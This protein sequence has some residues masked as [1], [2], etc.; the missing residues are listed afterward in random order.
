MAKGKRIAFICHP[1]H[2]GGVTR[3][4]ADAANEWSGQGNEVY[5]VT[6]DPVKEF[7]SAHG[8]ET[9]IQLIRKNDQGVK[10]LT[11]PAGYEFEFGT[12][13]YR[14]WIYK[15]LIAQIPA[16]TPIILSDDHSVWAAAT[17]LNTYYPVIGVMHADENHY[18]D[19]A[20][21]YFRQVDVFTCVSTRVNMITTSRVPGFDPAHIYTIPC[22]INL[23][24][25]TL[26]SRK[27]K[28]LQLVFV[29]RIS[30][31]QKRAG[32][33]VKIADLLAK[34]GV[35]FRMKIIGE[36]PLKSVLESEVE[37]HGLKEYVS[38][39]GWLSQQEVARNLSESDI[40]V[41]T[42]DFEG[43]PIAMMEAFAA[44]CGMVGTRVS[45]IEDYERHPLAG[46]CLGVYQVGAIEEAVE[47][48]I[49]ISKI[50]IDKRKK[51]ARR[52]A[53]SEFSMQVCLDRY[54]IAMGAI[55]SRKDATP[56]IKFPVGGLIYSRLIALSRAI[57]V[58]LMK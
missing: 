18:Y 32:D 17:A 9:L 41:L 55:K 58:R 19:L 26:S 51:A 33:L 37:T 21:K 15:K 49:R 29:G 25:F 40:L 45:G 22:G 30:E 27:D 56:E 1:Y 12:P 5:F 3:W 31:Y 13:E 34:K 54:L 10:L 23:P 44:G 39:P 43:T 42:S 6:V 4:M 52:L 47:Q 20:E 16:G 14:T 46:D 50:A 36:G 28:V 57:K 7:H 48:I 24:E 2:R 11:E 38:F 8:K 35:E 53:E